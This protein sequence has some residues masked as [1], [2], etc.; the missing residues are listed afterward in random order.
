[1]KLCA[2]R[3]PVTGA[4]LGVAPR[5]FPS[6]DRGRVAP[7]R[8][9]V[10]LADAWRPGLFFLAVLRKDMRVLGAA[11][12]VAALVGCGAAP[13]VVD[14]GPEPA[15]PPAA[16]NPPAGAAARLADVAG[17]FFEVPLEALP[18]H[19]LPFTVGRRDPFRFG[20]TGRVAAGGPAEAVLVDA[21]ADPRAV[22]PVVA[23]EAIPTPSA[24]DDARAVRFI[25]LVDV[26]GRPGP[27]AVLAAGRGVYHGRVNDVVQGRYRILAIGAA[28]VEVEAV[29]GGAGMT[30]RLRE[31]SAPAE[32]P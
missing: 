12:G 26:R 30:L 2:V 29:P 32:A 23:E 7:D 15:R 11:F 5:A 18:T 17:G 21:V 9:R 4:V 24:G 27:V 16:V 10:V 1:M 3:R 19:R 13:R 20:T 6:P 28:S 22:T 14:A 8:E 25:G 31:P